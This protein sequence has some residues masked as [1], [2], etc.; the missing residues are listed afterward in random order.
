MTVKYMRNT[1][2]WLLE[3][4]LWLAALAALAGFLVLARHISGAVALHGDRLIHDWVT[5]FSSIPGM[6]ALARVVTHFGDPLAYVVF[7]VLVLAVFRNRHITGA[8]VVNI[9]NVGVLNLILKHVVQRPRPDGLHLTEAT[10][11]SFPSGHAM[12][13]LAFYGFLIYLMDIYVE[14]KILKYTGMFLLGCLTGGIGLSR[15]YLGVHYPSDILGGY[16]ISFVYLV[17]YIRF[18]RSYYRKERKSIH[19]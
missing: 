1:F 10:G 7:S 19:G 14:N 18:T 13:S 4:T 15:I 17:V 11:Y 12:A 3:N 16:L 8:I 6:T 2:R 9:V 5:S